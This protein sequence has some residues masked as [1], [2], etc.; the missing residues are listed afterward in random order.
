MEQILPNNTAFTVKVGFRFQISSP[1]WDAQRCPE[2]LHQNAASALGDTFLSSFIMVWHLAWDGIP[3][4]DIIVRAVVRFPTV[5]SHSCSMTQ[6]WLALETKESGGLYEWATHF[7]VSL[8]C[9]DSV[10]PNNVSGSNHD[11]SGPS[12][13]NGSV[14]PSMCRKTESIWCL[15]AFW[16]HSYESRRDVC[17]CRMSSGFLQYP[18]IVQTST[19]GLCKYYPNVWKTTVL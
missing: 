8:R 19:L 16:H 18:E 17:L 3:Q 12:P 4:L 7:I 5:S 11:V 14:I 1:S 2:G 6:Q 15:P 9:Y 13:S 10:P